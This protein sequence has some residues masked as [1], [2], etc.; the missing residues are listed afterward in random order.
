MAE[1][2]PRRTEK[3]K[4]KK[5]QKRMTRMNSENSRKQELTKSLEVKV[6]ILIQAVKKKMIGNHWTVKRK[7]KKRKRRHSQYILNHI[8]RTN[9][10]RN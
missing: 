3:A 10:K 1:H 2:N 8:L 6:E 7:F 5:T 9:S 4:M